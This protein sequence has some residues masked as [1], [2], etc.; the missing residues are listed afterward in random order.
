MGQ[1]CFLIIIFKKVKIQLKRDSSFSPNPVTSDYVTVDFGT[2]TFYPVTLLIF[3]S[4][5]VFLKIP[6]DFPIGLWDFWLLGH[7]VQ[8]VSNSQFYV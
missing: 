7:G 2:L 5:V 6:E 1:I 3:I 8:S 4:M